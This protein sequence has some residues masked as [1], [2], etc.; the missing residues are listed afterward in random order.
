[1]DHKI[2][3]PFNLKGIHYTP[4]SMFEQNIKEKFEKL[5]AS[6]RQDPYNPPRFLIGFYYHPQSDLKIRL[7]TDAKDL[8]RQAFSRFSCNLE[9]TLCFALDFKSDLSFEEQWFG[10]QAGPQT[11]NGC[12][13]SFQNMHQLLQSGIKIYAPAARFALDK[14]CHQ[15]APTLKTI[16]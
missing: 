4:L 2:D 5:Q 15:N 7:V 14:H 1:M 10:C 9:Q 3:L 13:F 11:M 8:E 16:Q 6:Y 12:A